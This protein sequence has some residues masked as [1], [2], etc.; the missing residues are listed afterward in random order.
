MDF[1]YPHIQYLI[2]SILPSAA[3]SLSMLRHVLQD[4]LSKLSLLTLRD[5][6]EYKYLLLPASSQNTQSND[7]NLSLKL[8]IFILQ[9]CHSYCK[10]LENLPYEVLPKW[11]SRRILPTLISIALLYPSLSQKKSRKRTHLYNPFS[12]NFKNARSNRKQVSR[13]ISL[14]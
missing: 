12:Q 13:Y 4:G 2:A 14:N 8:L 1:D 6:I 10:T 5:T 7:L 9:H 3:V 11:V